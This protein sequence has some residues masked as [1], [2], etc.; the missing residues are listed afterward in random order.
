MKYFWFHIWLFFVSNFARYFRFVE[1]LNECTAW[2]HEKCDDIFLFFF[3]L[4]FL[5]FFILAWIEAFHFIRISMAFVEGLTCRLARLPRFMAGL[6][7]AHYIVQIN[8][9]APLARPGPARPGAQ[10]PLAWGSLLFEPWT[11][12]PFQTMA[13]QFNKHSGAQSFFGCISSINWNCFVSQWDT[14]TTTTTTW[15]MLSLCIVFRHSTARVC[16]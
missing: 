12:T 3:F 14:T 5:F 9:G 13:Q 16:A 1:W 8:K 4:F 15:T 2:A 7:M 10:P 11:L 6:T